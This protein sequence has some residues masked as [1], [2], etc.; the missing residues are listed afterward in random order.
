MDPQEHSNK[1]SS[2]PVPF[3]PRAGGYDQVP[4]SEQNTAYQRP[5]PQ[6]NLSDQGVLLADASNFGRTPSHTHSFSDYRDHSP[7]AHQP[8]GTTNNVP[9][10]PQPPRGNQGG[11]AY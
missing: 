2:F 11:Y 5:E 8:L 7:D 9:W 4:L 3:G 6:R 1:R 10:Q